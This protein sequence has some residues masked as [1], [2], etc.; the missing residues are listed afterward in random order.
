MYFKN[1]VV[2]KFDADNLPTEAEFVASL[3]SG[4]RSGKVPVLEASEESLAKF[5]AGRSAQ[6]TAVPS[7]ALPPLPERYPPLESPAR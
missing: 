5:G 4:R 3:D 2:E 6:A 1:D 7:P